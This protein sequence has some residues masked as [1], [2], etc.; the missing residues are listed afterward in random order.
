M[1]PIIGSGIGGK[2]WGDRLSAP[3]AVLFADRFKA[4]QEEN[5]TKC[6]VW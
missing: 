1:A 4:N 6:D 5:P 2:G 3:M